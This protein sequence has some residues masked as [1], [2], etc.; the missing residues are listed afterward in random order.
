MDIKKYEVLLN[1]ID[2]GSFIK[3]CEDLGYTQSGLTNM[4]NSLE[5]EIGFPIL[6]R[7]NKGVQATVDGE[8]VLP[9]IRELVKLNEKLEQEFGLI[10]GMETGKVRIG[11]FPT[12]ACAWIPQLMREFRQHYPH[13]QIELVEDN[14]IFHL[15]EWL[16]TG[17]IDVALFSR[18]PKHTYAWIELKADPYMAV[19]PKGS[20]L[21]EQDQ[22]HAKDLMGPAFFLCRSL[23]GVDQDIDRYLKKMEVKIRTAFTSNS[24]YT[25]IRM[26]EAGLGVSILPELFLKLILTD[27]SQVEVRPL[28]PP[29]CRYIGLAVRTLSGLSPATERFIECTK[30]LFQKENIPS[31]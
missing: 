6:M 13:I 26:V 12:L 27:L 5:R 2:H 20:P 19:L 23:D 8:R 18:Q 17:F 25:I 30:K 9:T 7:S 24:D 16:S 11:S 3:A 21:A 10:R 31:F 1:I 28:S 14:S 29:F 15:E 4:M 22:I